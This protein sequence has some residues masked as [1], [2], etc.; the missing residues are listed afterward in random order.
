MIPVIQSVLAGNM[1]RIGTERWLALLCR[2]PS[3][4]PLMVY[5]NTHLVV[6]SRA[7]ISC[8]LT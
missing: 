2:N 1:Y 3:V 8:P 6:F 5:N 7:P 4:F